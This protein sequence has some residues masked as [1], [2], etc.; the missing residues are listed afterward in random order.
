[1]VE[2]DKGDGGGLVCP[3]DVSAAEMEVLVD[4]GEPGEEVSGAVE[5]AGVVSVVVTEDEMS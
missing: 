3:E 1:V 5:Q 2:T 4:C